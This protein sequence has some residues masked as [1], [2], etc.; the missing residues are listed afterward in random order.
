MNQ[1]STSAKLK[2][3][4]YSPNKYSYLQPTY[5]AYPTSSNHK[6]NNVAI[7]DSKLLLPFGVLWTSIPHRA[8]A[9]CHL[10]CLSS[11]HISPLYKCPFSRARSFALFPFWVV[12]LPYCHWKDFHSLVI[13]SKYCPI[14]LMYYHLLR[15]NVLWCSLLLILLPWNTQ[16]YHRWLS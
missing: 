13:L 2:F 8:A 6:Y 7:K 10:T 5:F 3:L 11:R 4:Q 9:L 1:K 12:T 15:C 14:K 16:P